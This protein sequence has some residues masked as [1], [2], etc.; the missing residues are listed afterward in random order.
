M[1]AQILD[2]KL[3]AQKILAKAKKDAAVLKKRKI[4]PKLAIILA[5]DSLASL[6]YI[7]QKQKAC[8]AAGIKHELIKFPEKTSTGKIINKIKDLNRNKNVHAILMQMP[9]PKHVEA[10][11]V[12]KA[13]DPYKDAD[14][15]HAYNV[16]KMFISKDFE[17]LVPCTAIGVVRILDFY[18][19]SVEG[20][21]AVVVGRSNIVGKPLAAMLL[22][23]NATVTVCH[24][25]TKN[26]AKYTKQAEILCVA[27][28]KPGLIKASMVSKGAAI[29]D[30]GFN[31]VNGR[32][33]GDVDFD[34]VRK[35][36]KWITPVP[37]GVGPMTVA[38]LMENVIK[39][40]KKLTLIS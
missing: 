3:V 13:I 22:N 8:D 34:N 24:S 37:G 38:C 4:H 35:K 33:E 28:G 1:P 20:K 2:G 39:S 36:A 6:A 25:F 21:H 29:I 30:I 12:V 26:L 18:K 7:R 16:G 27:A 9:L 23:R 17:D 5:G 32:I 40:A 11:K 31:R 19:I 10:S 14:G 15:F